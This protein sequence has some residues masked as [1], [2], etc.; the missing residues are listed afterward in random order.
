MS[1]QIE[2]TDVGAYALGLLEDGDRRAFE[3]HLPGCG[4]CQAE[5]GELAGTAGALFEVA[6]GAAAGPGP[7]PGPEAAAE[8]DEPSTPPA[9]VIDM[10]RRRRRADRRFR[11]GAYAAGTAAAAVALGAGIALGTTLNGDEGAN[12]KPPPV[13]QPVT[14]QQFRATDAGTG[15][16]GTVGLVDK[17][18]GTQVSLELRGIK[19]P[20]RCHLE[21]VSRDGEH[22]VVAGWRVPDKGYGVPG[23]PKPL[24]MQGG[25]GLDRQQIDHFAVRLD[26]GG[27]LLTIPL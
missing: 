22:S 26:S 10:M 1:S 6:P 16:S 2:H 21:A 12:P 24:I 7:E 3:A 8:E 13:A 11:R 15:A 17:G 5:L 27:T 14:G 4:R 23:Q 20:L 9:P 25:T 19:G 18:W